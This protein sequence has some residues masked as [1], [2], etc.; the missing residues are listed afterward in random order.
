VSGARGASLKSECDIC[1]CH[2]PIVTTH[3]RHD[4]GLSASDRSHDQ[5][6]RDTRQAIALKYC[7]SGRQLDRVATVS[8]GES[9]R[10]LRAD[11]AAITVDTRIT[12]RPL[13]PRFSAFALFPRVPLIAALS[14][15]P[16]G[17]G[18]ASRPLFS[19]VT[20]R[21]LQARSPVRAGSAVAPA[22]S[23]LPRLSGRARDQGAVDSLLSLLDGLRRERRCQQRI[24]FSITSH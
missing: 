6:Q 8:A 2:V 15:R 22:F 17:A 19:R 16:L 5:S 4:H 24:R 13:L 11:C 7:A 3:R 1:C 21:S 10:A 14:A 20:F 18:I 12:L 23:T 9:A